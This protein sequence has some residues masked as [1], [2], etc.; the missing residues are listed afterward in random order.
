MSEKWQREMCIKL[1]LNFHSSNDQPSNFVGKSISEFQPWET[2]EILRDGNCFFR[3]LSKILTGSQNS[4]LD[5]RSIICHFIATEGTTQFGWYFHQKGVTPCE[6]FLNENLVHLEDMWATDAEVMAASAILDADI[7]VANDDY[8]NER[9]CFE[10]F[11]GNYSEQVTT[12]ASPS[13]TSP[14]TQVITNQ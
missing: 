5:L 2:T 13:S 9:T 11:D 1:G 3:C 8:I 12:Q 14:T 6:Y 4:H 7:Y 10:K